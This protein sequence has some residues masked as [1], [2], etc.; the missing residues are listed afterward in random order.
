MKKI[1][2]LFT[3]ALMLNGCSNNNTKS[4]TEKPAE[5]KAKNMNITILLDL[6]DR[7]S[8][9]KNPGQAERDIESVLSVVK[10]LKASLF[11]KG[12]INSNDKIKVVF[13][14][15]SYN[16]LIQD[17]AENLNIDFGK[18]ETSMR[19]KMYDTLD[20]LFRS[21]LKKLYDFASTGKIFDGSDI[22]SYFKDRVEDDCLSSGSGFTDVLVVLT[23]GYMYYVNSKQ[24]ENNRASFIT[25]ESRELNQLRKAKNPEE[26]IDNNDYGF[27]SVNKK[28]KTLNIL[29]LELAPFNNSSIDYDIIKKYWS[30]W[31]FEMESK[32]YKLVKTD[33]PSLNCN[34]IEKYFNKL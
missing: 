9:S 16:P 23:D 25:P 7:I 33:N 1:I 14:P 15:N 29:V 3:A 12:T 27:I 10:S 32:N 17:I 30:K 5:Q 13:Y 26:V 2:I 6:S 22:F 24:T 34:I 28:F 20:C 4:E 31:F 21:E 19:K 8:K 18:I 11:A